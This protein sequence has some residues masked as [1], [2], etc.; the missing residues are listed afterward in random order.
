[1]RTDDELLPYIMEPLSRRRT[2]ASVT[3]IVDAVRSLTFEQFLEFRAALDGLEIEEWRSELAK[4][5]AD[6]ERS[7]LTDDDIDRAVAK[8]RYESRP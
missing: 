1:V 6:W 2:M 4:S 8:R 3:E 5:T 7:G